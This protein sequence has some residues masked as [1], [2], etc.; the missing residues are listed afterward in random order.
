[1]CLPSSLEKNLVFLGLCGSC[2][3]REYALFKRVRYKIDVESHAERGSQ[4][5]Q[6]LRTYYEK[7][8]I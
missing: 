2:T 3:S 5:Q 1:M 7:T 8:S 6:D 4:H